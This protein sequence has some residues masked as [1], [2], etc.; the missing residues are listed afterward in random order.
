MAGAITKENKKVNYLVFKII[1]QVLKICRK[2]IL[3]K[4]FLENIWFNF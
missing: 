2:K 4:V 3:Q 1:L